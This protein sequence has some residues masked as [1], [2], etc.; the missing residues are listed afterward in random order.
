MGH[1]SPPARIHGSG[2]KLERLLLSIKSPELQRGGFC[3]IGPDPA[4]PLIKL[5]LTVCRSLTRNSDRS[6]FLCL[7]WSMR[8]SAINALGETAC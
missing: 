6:G 4:G 1:E 7:D 2:G 8:D 5:Q 3:E